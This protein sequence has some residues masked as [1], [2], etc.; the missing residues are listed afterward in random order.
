[1][2][3]KRSPVLLP[4]RAATTRKSRVTRLSAPCQPLSKRYHLWY[5]GRLR[6]SRDGNLSEN[7]SGPCDESLVV[8]VHSASKVQTTVIGAAWMSNDAGGG[9]DR[10]SAGASEKSSLGVLV[11]PFGCRRLAVNSM[12]IVYFRILVQRTRPE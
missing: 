1:M 6:R 9:W 2:L 7:V 8:V 4:R 11:Y 3:L 10:K 12:Y 5:V